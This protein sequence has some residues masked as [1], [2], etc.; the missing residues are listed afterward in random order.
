[1]KK[2]DIRFSD[3]RNLLIRNRSLAEKKSRG[4]WLRDNTSIYDYFSQFEKFKKRVV[5]LS[6]DLAE[7][8]LE[9]IHVD[10]CGR[11][12]ADCYGSDRSFLF[13]LNID[14]D[15][16]FLQF[17]NATAYN[18]DI[19][20][21]RDCRGFIRLLRSLNVSPSLITF[22]PV[23]GLQRYDEPINGM[24]MEASRAIVY[25]QLEKRL[26]L[27]HEVLKP[28]GLIFME[29]PFQNMGFVDFAKGLP[30]EE[31]E[32]SLQIKRASKKLRCG[33]E[34]AK[35]IDGPHYLLTK[36]GVKK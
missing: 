17:R 18:G 33:Y 35:S 16:S 26:F 15:P 21:N 29:R 10:I 13:A 27:F 6:D 3:I 20:R 8:K 36:R 24:D 11:A 9:F 19:F 7:Q 12:D 32:V 28:G 30:Q 5:R 34:I 1:M 23:A 14:D 2:Y 4:G 25:R 31:W 22:R